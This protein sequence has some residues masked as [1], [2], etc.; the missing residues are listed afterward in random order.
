MEGWVV[1]VAVELSCG[2]CCREL[3]C[4]CC[5]VELWLLLWR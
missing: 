5:G 4:G 3:S 1:V 2:C